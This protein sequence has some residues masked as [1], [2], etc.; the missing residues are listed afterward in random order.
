[1]LVAW[2]HAGP[3]SA[4]SSKPASTDRVLGVIADYR[5]QP[6]G[7]LAPYRNWRWSPELK[8]KAGDL[9]N[10]A[11][12][13]SPD[14][15]GQHLRLVVTPEFPWDGHP[16]A[17]HALTTDHFPPESDAIVVRLRVESGEFQLAIGGPTAYFG[18]SDVLTEPQRVV[19][20]DWQDVR[21]DLHEGLHRNYRRAGFG[22][23]A[24]A[25]SYNRWAQE[26][27][28]LSVHPGSSGTLLVQS[29]T[30]IAAGRGQPFPRFDRS[31]LTLVQSVPT[32]LEQAFTLLLADSQM[33]EFKSSW[34]DPAACRYAPPALSARPAPTAGQPMALAATAAWN[35]EI[36]W[37]GLRTEPKSGADALE[38]TVR[39]TTSV[40][41]S[42]VASDA[43]QPIDIGLLVAPA[44]EPFPWER[45]GPPDAWRQE[46]KGR[47]YDA[48]L[49]PRSVTQQENLNVALYHARRFVR[50]DEWQ[51]L[52]I[53]F[54][55]FACIG[56][57]GVFKEQLAAHAP[58]TASDAP[59]A[60]LWLVPWPRRGTGKE[61]TA[62][63]FDVR[64]VLIDKTNTQP[65][66]SYPA[67]LAGTLPQEPSP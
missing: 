55:D 7:E 37:A 12:V 58:P 52:V 57:T 48:N 41:S 5:R 24:Q 23:A 19:A 67:P 36:R 65:R 63:V 34:L 16:I 40:P 30:L 18:D 13:S 56:A 29:V 22:R 4:D 43:G 47:G 54:E 66:R 25:M 8:A 46:A 32:S 20:G 53:P 9:S 1:M 15:N 26:P 35:E 10:R 11:V 45:L 17:M 21:F 39:V 28:S 59:S 3:A 6:V 42:Q 31:D 44:G 62:E 49:S 27:P 2:L 64:L 33:A 51:S 50:V 60:V 61:S 14:G 38:L